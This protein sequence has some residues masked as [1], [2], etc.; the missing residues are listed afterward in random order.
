MRSGRKRCKVFTD[1]IIAADDFL[2]KQLRDLEFR[3]NV[4]NAGRAFKL[5]AAEPNNTLSRANCGVR[6]TGSTLSLLLRL[7]G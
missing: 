7:L 4:D 1:L 2:V 6:S 3:R 5:A